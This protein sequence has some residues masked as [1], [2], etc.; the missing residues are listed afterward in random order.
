MQ[1]KDDHIK[2]LRCNK[3]KYETHAE[4]VDQ[5]LASGRSGS[6]RSG[7]LSSLSMDSL[8]EKESITSFDRWTGNLPIECLSASPWTATIMAFDEMAKNDRENNLDS[9]VDFN[10]N[11]S[12]ND[13]GA[14]GTIVVDRQ[15]RLSLHKKGSILGLGLENRF[16]SDGNIDPYK[17][18]AEAAI[19]RD[20][21]GIAKWSEKILSSS[22]SAS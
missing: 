13:S 9:S 5:V 2:G 22:S 6:P 20:K 21:E 7:T 18:L 3:P 4:I 16:G 12:D 19:R 15:A 1:F 14:D 10:D 8:V 11:D 17:E